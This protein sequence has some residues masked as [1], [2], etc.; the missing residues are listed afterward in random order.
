MTFK[1]VYSLW[2]RSMHRL[3]PTIRI[4]VLLDR[5]P[6]GT[7]T[8]LSNSNGNKYRMKIYKP[9][10][11]LGFECNSNFTSRPE[12]LEFYRLSQFPYI[13]VDHL[14]SYYFRSVCYVVW[15]VRFIYI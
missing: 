4:E 8:S 1:F 12:D 13:Y 2:T 9:D 6:D 7:R 3:K 5:V 11:V 10:A 15:D 14:T